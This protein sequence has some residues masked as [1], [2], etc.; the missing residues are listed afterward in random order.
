MRNFFN[1]DGGMVER[2]LLNTPRESENHEIAREN[3][4]PELGPMVNMPGQRFA[5]YIKTTVARGLP[6]LAD[7]AHTQFPGATVRT[8]AGGRPLITLPAGSTVAHMVPSPSWGDGPE[9]AL[10]EEPAGGREFQLDAPG[11]SLR[12]ALN[13]KVQNA[14]KAAAAAA[15]LTPGLSVAG[16]I[17]GAVG[18]YLTVEEIRK[19]LAQA[20]GSK[21]P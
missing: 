6:E 15:A 19:R 14:P 12:N 3:G 17:L 16:K 1:S 9:F 4:L 2:N 20:A 21:Q 13:D 8:G 11:Y 10:E 18:N 7:I 5:G